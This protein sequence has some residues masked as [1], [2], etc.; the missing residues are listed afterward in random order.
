MYFL[1]MIDY[2]IIIKTQADL[3]NVFPS[4]DRFLKLLDL[5]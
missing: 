2:E 3:S 4:N 1:P 5:E